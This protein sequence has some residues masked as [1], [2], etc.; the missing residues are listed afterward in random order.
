M[1]LTLIGATPGNTAEALAFLIGVPSGTSIS[2][3]AVILADRTSKYADIQAQSGKVQ[4]SIERMRLVSELSQNTLR[5]YR[6][7]GYRISKIYDIAD[8]CLYDIEQVMQ[9]EVEE[10]Y[11]LFAE[12]F[13]PPEFFTPECFSLTKKK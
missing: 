10:Q 4:E 13:E 9:K 5:L 11:N 7:L 12:E 6:D 2:Y 3:V 8:Q 1:V